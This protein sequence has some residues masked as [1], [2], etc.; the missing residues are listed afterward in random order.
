MVSPSEKMA[1]MTIINARSVLGRN[2]EPD[3]VVSGSSITCPKVCG[4]CFLKRGVRS[5]SCFDMEAVSD[6]IDTIDADRIR[7]LVESESGSRSIAIVEEEYRR[8]CDINCYSAARK[9]KKP[10]I[11]TNWK[12][13]AVT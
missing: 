13:E 2:A 6:D 12:P 11:I 10:G 4:D 8:K 9:Q 7:E 1:I 5:L 3:V